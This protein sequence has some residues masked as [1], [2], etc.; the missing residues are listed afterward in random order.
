MQTTSIDRLT[1]NDRA[2]T[3]TDNRDYAL[4]YSESEFQRLEAQAAL[5]RDLTEDV[6]RRAG[7]ARGMRVL[8]IGCGVG[9]VSLLAAELVGPSGAVLGV[10]RSA[11]SIDIARRRAADA[12]FKSMSFAA[13]EIDAFSTEE[14]FDA[15]IGRLILLY[16]SEP[17]AA[18]RRLCGYL[19]PGG[20]VA[21]QEMSMPL[22]RS[23]PDG[24]LYNLCRD[25]VVETFERANVEVDMGGKLFATFLAAGLPAPQMIVAGRAGG[26]PQSPLYDYVT[27]SIGSLLPTME[28]FGVATAADVG[29][30]TLASRLRREAIEHNACIMPPPLI[31]AW[32][33]TPERSGNGGGCAHV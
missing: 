26:G 28:R 24:A 2:S 18:L 12:G 20:I 9:D 30:D 6:L 25:W 29:I 27:D 32:T 7:I 21:F 14:K 23:C 5:F 31:G 4:G 15:V 22:A 19:C 13:A 1:Q 10:D 17:A 8:D 33:R 16:V 3:G 11:E